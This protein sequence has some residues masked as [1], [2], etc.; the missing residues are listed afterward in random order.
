[1]CKDM[2]CFWNS[3]LSAVSASEKKEIGNPKNVVDL[4]RALKK[5]NQ[6]TRDVT[7]NRLRL[8][9]RELKE[10]FIAIDAYDAKSHPNGYLCSSC[11]PFLLLLAQLLQVNIDHKFCGVQIHYRFND[12]ECARVLRFI[13][14]QTHMIAA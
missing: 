1:M 11:E 10:N 9:A 3:I 2:S 5:H 4:I 7:W 14:T 12:A 6:L 8:S 13:S